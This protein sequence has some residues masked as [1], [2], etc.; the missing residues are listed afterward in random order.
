MS[1]SSTDG[2]AV[3][4][5]SLRALTLAADAGRAS[6]DG[7]LAAVVRRRTTRPAEVGGAARALTGRPIVYV[8]VRRPA[9]RLRCPRPGRRATWPSVGRLRSAPSGRRRAAATDR[10][11]DVLAHLGAITGLPVAA[12]CLSAGPSAPGRLRA[13]P[14]SAGRAACS[15]T[16]CWRRRWRC[17]TVAADA[18]PARLGA[19]RPAS[20]V[21]AFA[22]RCPAGGPAG[23]RGRISRAR[24][25][26]CR[27]PRP[28]S[29]SAAAAASAARTGSRAL[30][31][32]A[33]AARRHARGVAGGDQPGLA[34]APA[35]GRP[36]RHQDRP[37]A[38]PGLRDQRR[39]PAHGG[40][41]ERQAPAWRSTPTRTRRSSPAPTTR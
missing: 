28:G 40:L 21:H 26:G 2:A 3:A 12:D 10:G 35:A 11:S 4:D 5:A 20:T 30:E 27:W 31:E 15:R 25:P 13:D 38:V 29:W 19:E 36:D 22:A 6:G 23:A 37:G 18:V 16:P 32:L 33:G 34:A 1:W 24:R 39:D 9:G 7:R 14:A 8:V 41:P 17:S